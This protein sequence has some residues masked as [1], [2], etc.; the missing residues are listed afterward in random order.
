VKAIPG[1]SR[2]AVAGWLGDAVRVRV[3]APA[4]HG[5]ANR[6]IEAVIAEALGLSPTS[7]RVIA[8]RTSTRKI[9]EVVGLSAAE[10]YQRLPP[11]SPDSQR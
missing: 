11:A 10:V 9:V 5:K 8:G 2:D 3:T 7:V 6:A 1:S 4:E